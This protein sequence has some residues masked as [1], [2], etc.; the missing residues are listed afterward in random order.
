MYLP[1]EEGSEYLSGPDVKS[2]VGYD[3]SCEEAAEYIQ[4]L[5]ESEN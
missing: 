2:F 5:L 4:P 3:W 1:V